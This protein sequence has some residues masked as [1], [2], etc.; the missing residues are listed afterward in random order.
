VF[1]PRL[2]ISV[3]LAWAL[4]A[5]PKPHRE[6][7]P[8]RAS[9]AES[10]PSASAEAPLK[11]VPEPLA[12]E[13]VDIP[14][15]T[16]NVGSRPGEPGR[17]PELEPRLAAIEL[18]PF[19]IDRLP[20]PNDPKQAPRTG[21]TRDEAKRA[22]AERGERL[23][24]ELEWERACKGPK[25]ERF[26]SGDSFDASCSQSF[27]SCASGFD[28]LG[29][30]TALFE[31][32][33]S[34][35]GTENGRRAIARGGTGA[36]ASAH[37]CAAR[38]PL[39]PSTQSAEV[40]FRC[41][42]GAPNAAAVSEPTLE[43]TFSKTKLTPEQL[44]RL[45]SEAPATRELAHDIHF[46]KDPDSAETVIARGPGDRKGFTFGTTPLLW[47]P[48]AGA[49]FLLVTARAGENTSFVVA[50]Y[51]LGDNQYRLASSFILKNEPGPVAFAYDNGL[52]PRLHFSTCWGCPGETGKAIFRRPETVVIVQP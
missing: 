48:V 19:Q 34:E 20:Y 10:A 36:D 15:G 6:P 28:A 21:V 1:R 11:K 25:N 24:T 14:G 49:Q 40:G 2:L 37:R 4:T 27:A 9:S 42:Y 47:N 22:C 45:L 31:W 3:A 35:L 32:T 39:E 46:F 52:R 43:T 33:S 5:C 44:T 18:G 26:S 41:C 7:E 8:R 12:N 30:G 29:M 13:R 17:N 38:R 51:V 50:F 23:C 16:F